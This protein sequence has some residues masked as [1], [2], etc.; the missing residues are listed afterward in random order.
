LRGAYLQGALIE[1]TDRS[2]LR[3]IVSKGERTREQIIDRALAIAAEVGLEGVTL[4]TLASEL[5]LSKSGLFAHFRSKEALQLQVL[6]AATERF[7]ASVM[8]PA[9]ERPRGEPR[10]RALFDTYIAWIRG[11]A[12]RGGCFFIALGHEYDDRPGPVRDAVVRTQRE[13]VG[14]LAKAAR[15][16]VEE[17]HFR[18][19]LDADVFAQEMLG[20]AMAFQHAFKLLE[21]PKAEKKARLVFEGLI[22][23][24]R[25]ACRAR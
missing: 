17:G 12:S 15:L 2:T 1:S 6:Q 23:R 22:E 7:V 5:Q 19:D 20:V 3:S 14:V 4:G 25:S 10:V 13:W 21:D 18:A 24:S 8:K 9:F 16:A 11:S